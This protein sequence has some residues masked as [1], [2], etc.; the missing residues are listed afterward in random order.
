M[1]KTAENERIKLRATWFN[2]V[3]IGLMVAGFLVPYLAISQRL[4]DVARA[5]FDIMD[6]KAPLTEGLERS[7]AS[8]VAF[9]LAI[10]GARTMR[11]W[12]DEEIKK[13]E[14]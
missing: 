4:P 3:S 6:G 7:L 13:I 8:I 14:D 1:G 10:W 2:N 11:S 12:A 9:S 5:F